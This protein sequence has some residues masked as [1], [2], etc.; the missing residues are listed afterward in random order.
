[1]K[2]GK[3]AIN[4]VWQTLFP[5]NSGVAT[6]VGGDYVLYGVGLF[7]DREGLIRV[8]DITLMKEVKK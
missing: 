8:E 4:I 1:M 7:L 6:I 3:E 5:V 2:E